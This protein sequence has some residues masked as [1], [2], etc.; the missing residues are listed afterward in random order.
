MNDG[1]QAPP[2]DNEPFMLQISVVI[3]TKDRKEMVLRAM[4]SALEQTRPPAEVIVVDDASSDGTLDAVRAL[5]D[6]CV[7]AMASTG[8]GPA[9]ARNAGLLAAGGD[10]VA[11][12]DSDDEWM[13]EKLERQAQLFRYEPAPVL[14][15]SDALV[16]PA[17]PDGRKTIFSRQPPS[18]GDIF[19]PLLLDN[20][21]P[22]S[23]VV[24][25][26]RAVTDAGVRF[27][28]SFSPAEDYDFWL[29]V[30]LLGRC[31]FDPMPLSVYRLHPDQ[32]GRDLSAMFPACARVIT[33][34]LRTRGLSVADIPGLAKRLRQL[35]CAA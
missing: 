12:L 13:P 17:P 5:A 6:P 1:G 34:N 14:V 8:A 10:L 35:R 22:T 7:R 16:L 30:S 20:F 25:A 2:P 15:F 33:E 29:K 24:I 28:P 11:F 31:T 9:H 4:R 21:I 18:H 27:D 32:F 3:P 26:R 19:G 23:S